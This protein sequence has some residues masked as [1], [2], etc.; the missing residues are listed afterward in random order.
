MR[1]KS[2]GELVRAGEVRKEQAELFLIALQIAHNGDL[3]LPNDRGSSTYFKR[4][5]CQEDASAQEFEACAAVDMMFGRKRAR[6]NT[7]LRRLKR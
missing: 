3:D 4:S 5:R 7:L 2:V 1:L 6:V